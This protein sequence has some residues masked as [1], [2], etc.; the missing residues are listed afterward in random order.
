M[1]NLQ[2]ELLSFHKISQAYPGTPKGAEKDKERTQRKA[3]TSM[4]II[5]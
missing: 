2:S 1:G 4:A 5:Q 3:E